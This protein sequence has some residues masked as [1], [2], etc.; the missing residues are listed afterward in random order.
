[1]PKPGPTIAIMFGMPGP[2]GR[3]G[4]DDDEGDSNIAT[5]AIRSIARALREGGPSTVKDLRQ[6]T[7]ALEDMCAAFMDRDERA[8]DEAASEAADALHELIN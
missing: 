1:M 2:H 5:Q 6:Y 7:A 8:F 3:D 4:G